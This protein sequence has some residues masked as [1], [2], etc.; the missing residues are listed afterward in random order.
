MI[1]F[2]QSGVSLIEVLVAVLVLALG[3]IGAA[4]MQLTA[5]RTSR[6]SGLQTVALQL[7]SELADKMRSNDSQMKLADGDNSFLELDYQSAVDG[8]PP[9]PSKLCHSGD[10]NAKEAAEYDL[11]EWLKHLKA[12][13]PDG[14]AV[15]CRDAQPWNDSAKELNWN[16]TPGAG[17]AA[18]LVIKLGW[19]GKNPDG[20]LIRNA[21]KE[22]PPSLALTVEPYVK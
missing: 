11:Y 10:C 8:D 2:R 15:V 22:F 16:C 6:Q 9:P 12:A 17:S 18:S 20:T 13:L 19:Q 7:A 3:V 21:A 1:V 14:R 4:G 5:M